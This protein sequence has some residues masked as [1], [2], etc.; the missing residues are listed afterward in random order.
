VK[1]SA[2][3]KPPFYGRAEMVVTPKHLV[4]H[5]NHLLGQLDEMVRL[6][7]QWEEEGYSNREH[8]DTSF[9][10]NPTP[11]CKW[12]CDFL[13]VCKQMDDGSNF[14]HTIRSFYRKKPETATT[15]EAI[16]G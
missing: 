15:Q 16:S 7:Q 4:T 13:A 12:D 10:P 1:R 2:T 5:R 11:D 9:Y 3:A 6:M 14:E 8:H